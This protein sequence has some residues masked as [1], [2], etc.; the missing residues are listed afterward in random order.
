MPLTSASFYITTQLERG[1]NGGGA[2]LIN[3]NSTEFLKGVTIRIQFSKYI[4]LIIA[5]DPQQRYV[6][7]QCRIS[8]SF[9]LI[10]II[11]RG[12]FIVL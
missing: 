11:E 3:H 1:K 5:V 8:V 7:T 9:L 4:L 12:A 10:Q 6:N 2:R